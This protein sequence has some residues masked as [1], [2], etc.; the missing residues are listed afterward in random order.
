LTGLENLGNTCFL[1]SCLQVINHIYELHAFLD[2]ETY[3]NNIKTK[4]LCYYFTRNCA[5]M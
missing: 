4:Q 3:I 5:L 1:N 2:S